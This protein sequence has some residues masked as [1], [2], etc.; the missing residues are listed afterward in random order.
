MPVEAIVE[1]V[2]QFGSVV[3]HVVVTGGEPMIAKGIGPLT[4]QLAAAGYHITIETAGTVY[5]EEVV[6]DLFS[7]SPKLRNSVPTGD[8]VW[9]ERHDR[10]RTNLNVIRQ[11]MSEK[12]YQLKFVVV[13]PSDLAE[14]ESLVEAVGPVDPSKILL[15]PEAR[16][17]QRLNSIAVWLV[18]E[19]KHRGYRFCDRLHLRIFGDRR[20]T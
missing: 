2:Q 8:L 14:I 1:A 20:G 4:E 19:C 18:E 7:I 13:E 12:D 3:R 15:M 5:D 16:D 6:A 10:L 9:S 11:M 17:I